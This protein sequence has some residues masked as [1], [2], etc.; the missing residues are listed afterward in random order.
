MTA[1]ACLVVTWAAVSSPIVA[2]VEEPAEPAAVSQQAAVVRDEEAP[3][4]PAAATGAEA[5]D[6]LSFV[7]LGH[8]RGEGNGRLHRLMDELLEE[9]RSLDPAFAILTGD[10]IWGD[11]HSEVPD[12]AKVLA[13]WEELDAALSTLG[14]PI[15]RVPGNHD[16]AGL[17]TR[18][19][20]Y[21]RYG[22]LPQVVD[23][24]RIRLLLLNSAWVPED[25]DTRKRVDIRG[26]QLDR[27]Q[28]AFVDSALADTAAYDHAFVAM[29]HLLWWE[30]E[31]APWWREVHPTL[32]G[33]VHSVFSGDYGPAKFSHLDRDGVQYYQSG[34][35]GDPSLEILRG[36][37]WNRILAQQFDNFL[38]VTVDGS[39]VDV[40]VH[41]IGEVSTGHFTSDRWRAVHGSIRRPPVPYFGGLE[42]LRG[43]WAAMGPVLEH[44]KARLAVIVGLGLILSAV[45]VLGI[46]VGRRL[47]RSGPS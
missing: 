38:Y 39:D 45:G 9:V 30:T 3:I 36:H 4:Q 35:S 11:Y 19:I 43:V 31:D 27:E 29:H 5:S 40:E 47:G 15:Y 1:V 6:S 25:G 13:Q 34:I 2:A 46:L 14:I 17:V 12:S 28:V 18:D 44:P 22:R 37:E 42:R 8:V 7:V 26:Q 10:M 41:T 23:I 20:Y 21:E 33:R 16:I 32:T 24:G